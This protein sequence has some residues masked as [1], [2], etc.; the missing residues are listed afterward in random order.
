MLYT[1][2][3]VEGVDADGVEFGVDR[4][5]DFLEREA[6]SD[7]PPEDALRQLVRAVLD[8]QRGVLRDDATVVVLRWEGPAPTL[9]VQ[10]SLSA[11]LRD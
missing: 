5:G 7:R 2:G 9:P 3:V 4:L 6:A 10:S 1:D 8:H 11:A